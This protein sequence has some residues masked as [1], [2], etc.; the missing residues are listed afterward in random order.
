MTFSR[1]E[2]DGPLTLHKIAELL[3]TSSEEVADL[4]GLGMDAIR[5]KEQL[6]SDKT[7][8]RLR[9]MAEILNK[10]AL[11]FG[12][13]LMAYAWYRSEPL[14]GLSGQTAMRLVKL[15]RA[16]EVLDYIDATD[17]GIHA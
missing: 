2:D 12:S 5:R 1:F 4:A 16:D 10:V 11:R 15:G 3:R 17:A 7:Q 6:S 9:E 14:A 8:Y 13:L